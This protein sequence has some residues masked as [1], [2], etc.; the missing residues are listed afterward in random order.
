MGSVD[1]LFRE[2]SF[3]PRRSKGQNFLV[4]RQV[5]SRIET[6][7][8]CPPGDVLLEVGGGTG[9][10]TERLLLKERPLVVVEQDHKLHAMLE[11]RFRTASAF[12]L[13]KADILELDI[14]S[15]VPAG[16]RITLVGNIPYYLTTPLVTGL[17]TG[18]RGILRRIYL[19]VQKEVADRLEAR[20]GTK[21]YGAL[22]LCARYFSEVRVH[23]PVPASSFKPCPKVGSAFISL[24]PKPDLPLDGKGEERLFRLVR[25]VFQSRRKT[26][27][28]SL[29]L[30]GKPSSETE[31]ALEACGLEPEVRGETLDLSKFIELSQAVK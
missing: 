27:R 12:R 16:G 10:L 18:P 17:L 25:A 23:F 3:R 29:K 28:N 2:H 15:F 9:V 7:V 26:L 22:T 14:P 20:P 21:A 8:E 5:L 1:D 4:D 24:T 19:M 13:V 31:K 11:K 30:L 6:T